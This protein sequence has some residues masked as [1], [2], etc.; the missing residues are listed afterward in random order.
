MSVPTF[1]PHTKAGL[2]L[3]LWPLGS[4]AFSVQLWLAFSVGRL[5]IAV[6]LCQC[7]PSDEHC[8]PMDTDKLGSGQFTSEESLRDFL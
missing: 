5:I 6:T 2:V 3:Q 8:S 7:N 1:T 4:S